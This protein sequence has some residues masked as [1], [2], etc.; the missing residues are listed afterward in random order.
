MV[1]PPSDGMGGSDRISWD[2]RQFLKTTLTVGTAATLAGCSGPG[3]PGENTEERPGGGQ[4]GTALS[5][6]GEIRDVEDNAVPN[7]TVAALATVERDGTHSNRVIASGRSNEDGRF[8]IPVENADPTEVNLVR[9]SSRI[10]VVLVA[11]YQFPDNTVGTARSPDDTWFGRYSISGSGVS[12]SDPPPVPGVEGEYTIRLRHQVLFNGRE[13]SLETTGTTV[14]RSIDPDNPSAQQLSTEVRGLPAPAPFSL[15]TRHV[16]LSDGELSIQ[17]PDDAPED[18]SVDY[19]SDTEQFFEP[20]WAAPY[21]DDE[22]D[23]KWFNVG[24]ADWEQ[25]SVGTAF[26]ETLGESLGPP[27]FEFFGGQA[28]RSLTDARR[29]AVIPDGESRFEQVD[30][31]IA[32]LFVGM[33]AGRLGD[34]G[35]AIESFQLSDDLV[36]YAYDAF[37]LPEDT[38]EPQFLGNADRP[39][40]DPNTYDTVTVSWPDPVDDERPPAVVHRTPLRVSTGQEVNLQTVN[41]VGLW[42]ASAQ[43]DRGARF[44]HALDVDFARLTPGTFGDD[45][46]DSREDS[47]GETGDEASTLSGEWTQAL[48]DAAN[49][50]YV[51]RS[52]PTGVP[53]Q[54]WEFAADEEFDGSFGS[55]SA[56]VTDG[57]L[58]YVA[59]ETGPLFALEPN[60]AV[61]WAFTEPRV[62]NGLEPS[63]VAVDGTHVYLTMVDTV[64]ESIEQTLPAVYAVSREDGSL[65]DGWTYNFPDRE[66]G[67]FSAVA[68]PTVANGLVYVFGIDPREDSG[69]IGPSPLVALDA[70]TGREVWRQMVTGVIDDEAKRRARYPPA[71]TDTAVY[72]NTRNRLHA[73]DASS[74]DPL[75]ESDDDGVAGFSPVAVAGDTAVLTGSLP[76]SD[77]TAV[78]GYDVSNVASGTVER[79]WTAFGNTFEVTPTTLA[80]DP[81][82]RTAYVTDPESRGR[83]ELHIVDTE[84]GETRPDPYT[85]DSVSAGGD[86]PLIPTATDSTVYFADPYGSLVGFDRD[87]GDVAVELE[88]GGTTGITVTSNRLFTGGDTLTSYTTSETFSDVSLDPTGTFLRTIRDDAT[89]PAIVS[90]ADFGISPGDEITLNV[91]GGWTNGRG[92]EKT[93]TIAVFSSSA[94]FVDDSAVRNRVPDAIDAGPDIQTRPTFRNQEPTDIPEDFAV[95]GSVTIIVP[96]SA[97]HLFLAARANFYRDNSDVNDDYAVRI[98]WTDE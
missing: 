5:Y 33:A 44:E 78:V 47:D 68:R 89:N 97:S 71:A 26:R 7:A 37:D 79:A 88:H 4:L 2:R 20:R 21:Q 54:E 61:R 85:D 16:P 48:T 86:S 30:E 8:D 29:E 19:P 57:E 95:D 46:S 31:D 3:D 72:L 10:D 23:A 15:D 52:G 1:I 90:L 12:S 39:D 76:D 83:D 63:G 27:L 69:V 17:I 75:W 22:T 92:I 50:S 43:S 40:I 98:V 32:N 55:Y 62:M 56:P 38:T 6:S 45:E 42:R 77:Y 35:K 14:W 25:Y 13:S 65:D 84:T 24:D 70:A 80:V 18:V 91:V 59:N 28:F 60:G 74:G 67:S 94:E 51:D 49:T 64:S 96:D 11:Q 66:F 53:R 93:D 87:S 82:T 81:T 73:Y 34:I 41:I 36:S 58:L 9:H